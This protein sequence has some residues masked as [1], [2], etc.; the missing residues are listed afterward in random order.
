MS[1]QKPPDARDLRYLRLIIGRKEGLT[2]E[3]IA[4]GAGVKSPKALYELIKADGHPICPKCGTTYVDEAHCE[5]EA[6]EKQGGGRKARSS[7]PSTQLPPASN[8]APLF[9]EKLGV[10]LR[11]T[12]ELEH[13]IEKLQGGRFFQSSVKPTPVFSPRDQMPEEQWQYAREVLGLD[14]EA[15]DYMYFGG[16]TWALGRG[17]AAPDAPLP[18]LIGAYLLAG[19]DVEPL[20]ELLHHNLASAEWKQIEKRIAGRKSVDGLDGLKTLARQLATLILGGEL[21]K[22]RDP[23][24]ISNREYNLASRI[25]E[26]REQGWSDEDVYQEVRSLNES[27]AGK[28]SL[29]DYQ[30]L[31]RLQTKYPWPRK[32]R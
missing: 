30:R 5:V 31:A 26:L 28:L 27:F 10:L 12:E 22:G 21:G 11:A 3:Q 29:E 6:T 7:G 20:V 14:P 15:K 4:Q 2:E 9:R 16:A 1:I 13:R 24:E 25:T 8:A 17:S 32:E 18:A 23:T 19:G